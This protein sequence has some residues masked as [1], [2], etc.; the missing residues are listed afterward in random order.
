MIYKTIKFISS[1]V[2][3]LRGQEIVLDYGL[4]DISSYWAIAKVL[5]NI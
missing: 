4:G 3:S 2:E 5:G 1:E